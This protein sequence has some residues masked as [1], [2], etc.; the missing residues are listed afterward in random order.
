MILFLIK[1]WRYGKEGVEIITEWGRLTDTY[2]HMAT[3]ELAAGRA[4]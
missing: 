1:L 2:G 4:S 3:G